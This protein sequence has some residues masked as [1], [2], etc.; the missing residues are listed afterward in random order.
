MT[1][2]IV[3]LEDTMS[4]LPAEVRAVAERMFAVATTTGRLDAPAAMHPWITKLFGSVDAVT[5]QRIVRVTNT[6]TMEGALFNDLRAMRPMEV[7]GAD[8]VRATIASAANDPFDRPLE[9]TP[10]DTFGRVR[11]AHAITASNVA[12][13]DGYHGVLVFDEHDP[14]AAIDATRMRDYLATVRRWGEAALA[15]DPSARYLFLMWNCLWRAGGSIVHGHMQMTATR[16][17]HYPKVE[18]LRR[19][20][21]AYDA[22]SGRDYFDDLWQVHEALGLGIEIDGARV[23]ASITPIKERE[24]VVLG[25]PGG[26]LPTLAPAI[27]RVVASYRESGVIAH[28]MAVYLPPLAPD[29][30]DW[31]RFPPSA[32]IVDRGDPA[33]KTSDIGAMELYA[34]SVIATD[35]FR[36]IDALRA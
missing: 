9:G 4:S 27:A 36:V 22:A 12:K 24:V 10:A 6:V 1:R 26:E 28:N 19:Q 7:K 29:G 3:D 14:L 17:T 35:P 11:G 21:L 18:S 2:T 23:M 34:A 13:Y 30:E 5:A 25:R 32:R 31:R 33:N 20:A 8:E 16:G 15:E